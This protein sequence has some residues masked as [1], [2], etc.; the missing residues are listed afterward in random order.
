[1]FHKIEISRLCNTGPY[2]PM[3]NLGGVVDGRYSTHSLNFK[4]NFIIFKK[5]IQNNL[6]LSETYFIFAPE[7][8]TFQYGRSP[9]STK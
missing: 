4:K 6:D 2:D 3:Q 8:S 5:F 7:D 9:G 1:M